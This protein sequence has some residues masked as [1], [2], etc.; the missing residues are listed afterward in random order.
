MLNRLVEI[1]SK[2]EFAQA[3]LRV[4]PLQEGKY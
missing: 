1:F 3:P 2:K 4:D